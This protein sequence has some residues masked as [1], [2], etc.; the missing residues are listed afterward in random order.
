MS[1]L[2]NS[3]NRQEFVSQIREALDDSVERMDA[4]TRHAII[5]RR[6][7][8]LAKQHSNKSLITRWSKPAF[9][10]A[11]TVVIALVIVNMQFLNTLEQENIEALELIVAQD[12]L[13]MY[14]ELDFYAWLADEDVTT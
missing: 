11:A 12:T 5:T 13:E 9:A 6:K 1:D 14:E 8:A 2:K 4:D 3:N 10:I 7:R